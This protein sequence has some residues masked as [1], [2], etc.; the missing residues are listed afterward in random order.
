MLLDQER[1]PYVTVCAANGI[2][3]CRCNTRS[4]I[5]CACCIHRHII[6]CT[7]NPPG[8]RKKLLGVFKL[9][10]DEAG[11][12]KK[13]KKIKNNLHLD[14]P[15][16]KNILYPDRTQFTVLKCCLLMDCLQMTLLFLLFSLLQY[17]CHRIEGPEQTSHSAQLVWA[18]GRLS[19]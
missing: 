10:R 4:L 7:E 6:A 16:I 2:Y 12:N 11:K 15:R 5:S 13:R 3:E 1:A 8:W 19:G 17:V 9:C 14:T 18:K